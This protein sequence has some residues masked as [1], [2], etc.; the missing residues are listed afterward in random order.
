MKLNE[1]V[2][3]VSLAPLVL[4]LAIACSAGCENKEKVL[5]VDTPEGEVDVTRDR[6]TG[7]IDVEATDEDEK[8][9]DI[10]TPETDVEINR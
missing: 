4:G 1:I 6:D 8:L 7:E 10:D 3:A 5:E 9:I 2:A